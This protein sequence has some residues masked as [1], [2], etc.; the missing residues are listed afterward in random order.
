MFLFFL[1][2]F[3]K[4]FSPKEKVLEKY[5][6]LAEKPAN[7]VPLWVCCLPEKLANWQEN[8]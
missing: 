5:P 3:Y 4:K 7:P 1:F 8:T 2:I 6:K